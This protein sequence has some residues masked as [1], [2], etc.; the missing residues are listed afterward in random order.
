MVRRRTN[1][2]WRGKA[3]YKYD[4]SHFII[5]ITKNRKVTCIQP[6]LILYKKPKSLFFPLVSSFKLKV[7]NPNIIFVLDI[8]M[9]TLVTTGQTRMPIERTVL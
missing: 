8:Q 9:D 6:S 4:S 7:I 5:N 1:N 2:A 3:R